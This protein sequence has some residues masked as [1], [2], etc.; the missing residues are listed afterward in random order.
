MV[1][2]VVRIVVSVGVGVISSA[3]L[4]E[5]LESLLVATKALGLRLTLDFDIRGIGSGLQCR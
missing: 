3:A 2:I 1:F 4:S 5:A